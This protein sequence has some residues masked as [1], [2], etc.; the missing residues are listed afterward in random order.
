M[1]TYLFLTFGSIPAGLLATLAVLARRRRGRAGE[2]TGPS[3]TDELDDLA[4]LEAEARAVAAAAEQAL[5]A[6]DE[7]HHRAGRA[8][9]VLD[10]AGRRY[11]RVRQ[12]AQPPD[13]PL[14]LVERAALNAFRR[15]QLSAAQLNRIWQYTQATADGRTCRANHTPVE[16]DSRV[17]AARQRYEQAAI[18][19]T[20]VHKEVH[21]TTVAARV[22]AEETQLV[23]TRLTA[24]QRSTRTGLTALFLTE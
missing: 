10:H 23:E 18:E 16:R 21:V 17:H 2:Q 19:V 24:A 22:L 9:Q 11:R 3:V 13:H 1:R 8:V 15:G 4:E 6:A 14:Q 20:A 5:A 12:Q 7:A